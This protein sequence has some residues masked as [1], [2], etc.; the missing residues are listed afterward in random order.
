MGHGPSITQTIPLLIIAGRFLNP[1]IGTSAVPRTGMRWVPA[2]QG[3]GRMPLCTWVL[4]QSVILARLT[5][6]EVTATCWGPVGEEAPIQIK[7]ASRP[8]LIVRGTI[9][10]GRLASFIC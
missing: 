1:M 5:M 10:R 7:D 8:R 3:A 6:R 4:L 9:N 2:G